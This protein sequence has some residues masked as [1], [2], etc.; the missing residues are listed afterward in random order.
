M[1]QQSQAQSQAQTQAQIA[2][3]R[4]QNAVLNQQLNSQAQSHSQHLQQLIPFHQPPQQVQAPSIP[5]TPQ[6][7]GPPVPE[8][9]KPATTPVTQAGPSPSLSA[10][11]ILQQMK[12]T[13]ESSLQAMVD[14]TQERQATQPL[15][16][17]PPAPMLPHT[18]SQQPPLVE[19]PPPRQHSS[20]RSRSYRHH[21]SSRRHDK[22][23]VSIPRSPRCR[24]SPK[25]SRRSS[26][27]RSSS[28]DLPIQ[29]QDSRH[30]DWEQS[31]TLRS[32]S[33]QHREERH[34]PQDQQQP[35]EQYHQTAILHAAQWGH[36]PQTTSYT[37]PQARTYYH[38]H[39]ST[40]KWQSWG[41]WKDYSKYPSSSNPSKWI[42]YSQP[43]P[44]H[45]TSHESSTKPLTAFSSDIL[46][47]HVS[48]TPQEAANTCQIG[49]RPNPYSGHSPSWTYA[50]SSTY[51]KDRKKS[52]SGESGLHCA[53][54]SACQQPQR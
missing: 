45:H 46:R 18:V 40:D 42:D 53:T 50:W 26:R 31:I 43:S 17:H 5:P 54:L 7:S 39:S 23:P 9:P 48:T 3:L 10:E 41:Q 29:R 30:P 27:P 51:R 14:K 1:N 6:P 49:G 16:P 21:S 2:A 19:H 34:R 44:S 25:R 52:G 15:T 33:Q 47:P 38:E 36:N 4:E 37:D 11:E 28:R 20:R 24:R 13:V 12:H 35:R 22:R 8:P 32:A